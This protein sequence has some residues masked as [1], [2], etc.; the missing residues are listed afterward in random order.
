V[1]KTNKSRLYQLGAL[2][3]LFGTL[4]T[5]LAEAD[6]ENVIKYRRASMKSLG[7]HMGAM[8]QIVRGKVDYR[9]QLVLHAEAVAAVS[10]SLLTLFPEGSDFGETR[11]KES[12]WEKWEEFE[13]AA[14]K[15]EKAAAD[16]LAT[17][18]GADQAAMGKAFKAL[19]DA[20]K[21]CH[22]TFREKEE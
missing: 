17:A 18:R 13:K 21:G 3:L 2:L 6:P 7:G 22:K 10:K 15:G 8:A 16:F 14:G 4:G 11:A 19:S 1:T 9:D 5:A 20:C 12:V